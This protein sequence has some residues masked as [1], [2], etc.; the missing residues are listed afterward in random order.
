VTAIV[1]AG[2]VVRGAHVRD[3][4]ALR[5]AAGQ[6]PPL[7]VNWDMV[8]GPLGPLMRGANPMNRGAAKCTCEHG[9]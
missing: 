5:N 6:A 1:G 4:M 8:V 3:Q 2:L 7:L 9:H